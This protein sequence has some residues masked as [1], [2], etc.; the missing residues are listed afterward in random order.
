MNDWRAV[1]L[2]LVLAARRLHVPSKWLRAEA[3]AGRVPHLKADKVLL[4]DVDCV[5]RV[6]ACR[7]REG[8]EAVHE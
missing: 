6:L 7:A 3:D 8:T 5:A 2:P 1:L 4:F